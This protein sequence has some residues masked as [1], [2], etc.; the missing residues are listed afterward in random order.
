MQNKRV[1]T[2]SSLI[3][4]LLA[5]S[6]MGCTKSEDDVLPVS[7]YFI[8]FKVDGKQV[9]YSGQDEFGSNLFSLFNQKN[10]SIYVSV[11]SGIMQNSD[12]DN[13]HISLSISNETEIQ[14]N[15]TYTNKPSSSPKIEPLLFLIIYVDSNGVK[16]STVNNTILIPNDG[17]LDGEITYTE[18]KHTSVNGKFYGT[19]YNDDD[20]AIKLSEGEFYAPRLG[21]N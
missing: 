18:I 8:K 16:Y 11:A 2:L 13:N 4:T 9:T 20:G 7:E 10:D 15:S 12:S 3:V 6:L 5:F 17:V 21:N 19:V 1:Y 14:L